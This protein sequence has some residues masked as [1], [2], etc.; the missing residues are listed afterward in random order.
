MV[1]DIV[2]FPT[3]E[4]RLLLAQDKKP[5]NFLLNHITF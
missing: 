5:V 2:G 4:N 1:S 3:R